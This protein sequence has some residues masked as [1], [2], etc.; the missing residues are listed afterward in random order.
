MYCRA[1]TAATTT[2]ATTTT[3]S[4]YYY[5]YYCYYYCYYYYYHSCCFRYLELSIGEELEGLKRSVFI[6]HTWLCANYSCCHDSPPLL[7]LLQLLLYLQ[8]LLP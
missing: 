2:T 5:Y 7:L 3:S 8:L 6:R 4:Y 1:S